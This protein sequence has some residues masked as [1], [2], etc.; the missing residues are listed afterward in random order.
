M[1]IFIKCTSCGITL[2]VQQNNDE[3]FKDFRCPNCSH[4]LRAVFEQPKQEGKG[5][6]VYGG[7][8]PV[9]EP[10]KQHVDD[11]STVLASGNTA[12]HG[13]LRCGNQNYALRNGLNTVG[14]SAPT[15]GANVQIVTDDHYMS[16][17]HAII[18]MTRVANG[19]L[20]ALISNHKNKH[21]TIV[22]GQELLKDDELVLTNGINIKM[23]NTTLV[24]FEE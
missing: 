1:K 20:K 19:C 22:A 16:R 7:T 10:P 5:E 17:E 14:R 8:S 4:Q 9:K 21:A 2:G 6:T 18:K 24:Y 12:K 23:G 13:Y 3:P 11:G 15:S